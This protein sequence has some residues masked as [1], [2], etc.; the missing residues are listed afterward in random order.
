MFQKK[1]SDFYTYMVQ[2]EIAKKYRRV[3]L[4]YVHI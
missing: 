2:K 1:K 3:F 4:I